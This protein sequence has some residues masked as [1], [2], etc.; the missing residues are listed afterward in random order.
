MSTIAR[1]VVKMESPAFDRAGVDG[2]LPRARDA[3]R[4]APVETLS[5]TPRDLS[6]LVEAYLAL[7]RFSAHLNACGE[8]V[9]TLP[10]EAM[11]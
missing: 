10:N 2:W 3:T 6:D 9:L 4:R 5:Q 7:Q 11:V 8:R 1:Q